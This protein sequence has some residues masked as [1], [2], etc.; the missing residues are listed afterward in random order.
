MLLAIDIG[1]TST[2]IGVYGDG[3]LL[4]HWRAKTNKE[5]TADQ[6]AL[7]FREFFD[8]GNYS[9]DQVK[10]VAISNVVPSLTHAI[11]SMAKRYFKVEPLLVNHENA[12]LKIDYPNPSEIG[13]DR[14]VNAVAAYK[15][16]KTAVVVID[17]GTATTFDYIDD[18]GAYCGG[19]IVPGIM[20]SNEALYRWTSK[21]PRVD[22]AK[23]DKVITK[24][25]VDA[26]QSGVYH[27]YVGLV[28]YMIEKIALE[29]GSKPHVIAAGGL[30]SL[31]VEELNIEIDRFLTLE[32]LRIVFEKAKVR[33][34]EE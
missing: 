21:L 34:C 13:A 7:L 30:A 5:S 18:K 9:F 27:G 1:N 26:I 10:G 4:S 23:T 15:K 33:H 31:V 2:A 32:G 25:T 29:V 14:L 24:S 16:Y 3:D 22:I 28:K 11:K 6:F 8:L 12:G 19:A 17:F 20:I